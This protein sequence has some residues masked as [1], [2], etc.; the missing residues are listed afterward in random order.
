MKKIKVLEYQVATD[1]CDVDHSIE[2]YE[3]KES[4][5]EY[6]KEEYGP[7]DVHGNEIGSLFDEETGEIII[8]GDVWFGK[9]VI[10]D[11]K[12]ENSE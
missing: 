6:L 7:K 2:E 4:F 8:E 5:L 1:D 10:I 3:S 9:W 12:S 11:Y